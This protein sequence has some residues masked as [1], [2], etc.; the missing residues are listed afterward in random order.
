MHYKK[1]HQ[2]VNQFEQVPGVNKRLIKIVLIS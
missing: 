1:L 2:N